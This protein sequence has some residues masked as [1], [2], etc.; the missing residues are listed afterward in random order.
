MN[1]KKKLYYVSAAVAFVIFGGSIGYYILFKGKAS[2]VDCL[3][4]TIISLTT[5]GFGEVLP[6]TGNLGAQ[7]FTMILITFGMGVILYGISML[8]A[9]LI[10][11]ELSGILRKKQMEKQI[12]LLRE[13]FIVCGGGETGRPLIAELVKNQ[14]KVV[15]LEIDLNN[16]KKCREKRDLLYIHGDATEDQNLIAAGIQTAAGIL[17]CTPSDKDNLYVTMTARMLNPHIRIISRMIDMKLR[18]KLVKAGANS[19]VSPNSIGALRMASEMIRP[20]A[21]DFLDSMLRSDRGNLRINQITVSERFGRNEQTIAQSGIKEKFNILVLG[22]RDETGEI[23]FN[24]SAALTLKTGITLIVMGEVE[25]IVR[26][27]RVF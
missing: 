11:G 24:P 7:V 2:L 4:M 10:E 9:M 27:K 26:A 21:V 3:Y 13:H 17:I 15:L 23:V 22:A 12:R 14:V 16:I 6:V 18:P 25:D 5:V 20:E 1:I 19:V 8:T